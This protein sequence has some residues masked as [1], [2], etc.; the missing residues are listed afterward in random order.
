MLKKITKSL[1]DSLEVNEAGTRLLVFDTEIPGFGVRVT[2]GSRTF[3][4]QY[5]VGVGRG[6]PK[7]RMSVGRYG[8][9]TVE[10][11]RRLA[12]QRLGEVANGRDPARE[13]HGD[14][15]TV[16]KLGSEF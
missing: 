16:A 14:E 5:R 12:V 1:V 10:Q 13:R 2:P 6:A 7:R 11:A 3:F 15:P 4:V 8:A 9:I